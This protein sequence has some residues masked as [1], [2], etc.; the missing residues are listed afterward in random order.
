MKVSYFETGRYVSPPGLPREW[1]VPA[2]SYNPETGAEAYRGMVER[3]RFVEELG[4]D[5][6]SVSEHHYSPRIL[7]P[8]PV[9][10]AAYLEIGRAHV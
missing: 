3:V 8:S 5:W 1:P 10:S 7:T 2:G 9:V 6:V 4:F